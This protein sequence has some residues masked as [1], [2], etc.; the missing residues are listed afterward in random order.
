[1]LNLVN[2]W[3]ADENAILRLKA[4]TAVLPLIAP[5]LTSIFCQGVQ[6]GGFSH[7]I[8]RTEQRDRFFIAARFW[9]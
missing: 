9:R 4:Q 5:L 1:M 6:G 8:S 3:Y 7:P 2:V